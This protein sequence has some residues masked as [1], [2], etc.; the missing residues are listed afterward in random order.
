[1]CYVYQF[2]ILNLYAETCFQE[3][4]YFCEN[5]QLLFQ[6]VE[7]NYIFLKYPGFQKSMCFHLNMS[8]YH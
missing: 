8:Q 7:L 2:N 6:K 5:K 1:M 3:Q 4:K